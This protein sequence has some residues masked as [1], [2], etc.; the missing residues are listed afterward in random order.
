MVDVLGGRVVGPLESYAPGF[1]AGLS[2]QGYTV[3]GASQ[4]LSFIAHLSLRLNLGRLVL[5][6][7]H[8]QFGGL[9]CHLAHL[10]DDGA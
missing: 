8:G 5:D 6:L 10:G 1:A 7:F 9:G 2:R 4:H 3:S